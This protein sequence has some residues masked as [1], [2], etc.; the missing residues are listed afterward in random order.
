LSGEPPI[1][2]DKG[3]FVWFQVYF[4]G[5]FAEKG[6]RRGGCGGASKRVGRGGWSKEWIRDE[7]LDEYKDHLSC[8]LLPT[9]GRSDEYY[10]IKW[11]VAAGSVVVA[12]SRLRA[13]HKSRPSIDC[14]A[15]C[16]YWVRSA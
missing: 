14:E 15:L 16:R 2:A 9:F 7:R 5:P 3:V 1:L 13:S 12:T 6:R 11:R 8:F 4:D 10:V